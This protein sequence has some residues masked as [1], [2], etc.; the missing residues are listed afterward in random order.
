MRSRLLAL[1][2][3]LF[4]KFLPEAVLLERR[5]VGISIFVFHW[6]TDCASILDMATSASTKTLVKGASRSN[7]GSEGK[8]ATRWPEELL[9]LR[10][11]HPLQ[12]NNYTHSGE[13]KECF[14]NM[15]P[16]R[17]SVC[18]SFEVKWS[19]VYTDVIELYSTTNWLSWSVS[20]LCKKSFR[21]EEAVDF[22]G[23]S[24][25]SLF[26]VLAASLWKIQFWARTLD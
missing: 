26:R 15:H 3:W 9:S 13:K 1:K 11:K 5:N 4:K 2:V 17:R 25:W 22:G 23:V 16:V 19:P 24:T 7:H 20:K 18:V 6:F 14:G 21:G 8:G 10:L 12:K